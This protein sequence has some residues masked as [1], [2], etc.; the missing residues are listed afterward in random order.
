MLNRWVDVELVAGLTVV[1]PCW[2]LGLTAVLANRR[3]I[4]LAAE[5]TTG[6]LAACFESAWGLMAVPAHRRAVKSA[7]ELTAL[8]TCRLLA[9]QQVGG[10]A[11]GVAHSACLLA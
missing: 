9:Q 6:L 8:L 3:D 2:P 11:D 5:L 1:L 4:K 10:G 7:A